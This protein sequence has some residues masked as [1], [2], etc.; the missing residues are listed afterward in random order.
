MG[1]DPHGRQAGQ[2]E[3]QGVSV[4]GLPVRCETTVTACWPLSIRSSGSTCS[5]CTEGQLLRPAAAKAG[6]HVQHMQV[7]LRLGA[8]PGLRL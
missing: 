7:G 2:G 6:K 3:A 1:Q 5:M 8:G 4:T